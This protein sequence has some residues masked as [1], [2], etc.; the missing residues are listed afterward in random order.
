MYREHTH[1]R[2]CGYG[3]SELTSY[4]KSSKST[5]ELIP[6]FDLGL[7]PLA[8]DFRTPNEERSGYAPLKV[9]LCPKCGLAQLSVVVNPSILYRDYPYVT[10]PS[11]TM[12]EHF[13]RLWEDVAEEVGK[14]QFSVIEIGSNDGT[15]LEYFRGKG[16][17]PWVMGID[18]AANLAEI[19]NARGVKTIAEPFTFRLA[20]TLSKD[21]PWVD[22]ILARHVFCHVDDW[23]DFV[24]GLEAI[25]RPDTLICIEVPYVMDL[26]EKGELDSIYH[27]HLSYFSILPMEALLERTSL[28]IHGV[29]HYSIHGGALLVMLRHRDSS[30]QHHPPIVYR[31]N[32]AL[33]AD[34]RILRWKEFSGRAAI[35]IDELRR[36][37]LDLVSPG[38]GKKTVCGFGASAKS[39]VWVNACKFTQQHLKFITDTTPQKIGKLSPGSDIPIVDEGA[40]LRELPDYAVMCCWNY[41]SEVLEK[42]KRYL[43]LGG[44]FIIPHPELTIIGN[45]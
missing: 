17:T 37:V 20:N 29:T 6:V 3:R 42:H 38:C 44:H 40:L 43:E 26:L 15:L 13:S 24:R 32:E 45:G 11:K 18:P 1:C 16:K 33:D 31:H 39:T 12:R 7:Q 30:K 21:L 4:I 22:V 5:E 14:E 19:A 27:E 36:T 10:S 9:M 8:N 34:S 2:A 35:K 28:R 41:G 25:A 23:R